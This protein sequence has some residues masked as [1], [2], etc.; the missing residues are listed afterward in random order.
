MS[1]TQ[2]SPTKGGHSPWGPI[3]T[4]TFVADGITVVS[5]ASHGGYYLAPEQ[6]EKVPAPLRQANGW[7]EEDCEW[8]AVAFTFPDLF[9]A[10]GV[11]S[12]HSTLKHWYPDQYAQATGAT[13]RVEESLTLQR[14]EFEER[15]ANEF[16]VC[17]AF[18]DWQAGVPK[19][20]V[21]VYA[22]KASTGEVTWALVP[23]GEY[24]GRLRQGF[25]LNDSHERIAPLQG[26]MA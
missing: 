22:R 20:M 23:E 1:T 25:V 16:V 4:C 17:S 8:A 9:P 12:A 18:G 2:T 21:G 10:G 15:T 6:N 14:R 11:E 26:R 24:Q 13:V 5:T 7:Y 3:Q 19:G